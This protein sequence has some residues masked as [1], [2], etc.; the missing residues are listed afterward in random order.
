MRRTILLLSLGI[1]SIAAAPAQ[2]PQGGQPAQRRDTVPAWIQP[3]HAP[4]QDTIQG[5]PP[6]PP[7]GFNG[8]RPPEPPRGMP[9]GGF[10]G[11]RPGPG[12]PGRNHLQ[13]GS[14]S[15]TGYSQT[16]GSN[17]VEGKTY[18]S[19]RADENAV[20]IKGGTFTM[21]DCTI[22][23]KSGDTADGD[24]SSFFGTN[25]TVYA[26][27]ESTAV[28]MEGGRISSTATGVN[29]IIAYKGA[30][31]SARNVSIRTTG[32]FS[33]GL[34]ATG[35][36]IIQAQDLT[37]L[38]EG[39]NS[40]VIA[41]DRGGGTVTV[42]G[43]DYRTTGR[44]CA[45]LYSTG[46]ITLTDATGTSSQGE[47]G[48]I[49]GSNSLAIRNCQLTSGSTRRGLMVLQSG[50]GDAEGF[51]GGITVSGGELTLTS[52]TA[53]LIEVPTNITATITLKDVTLH[54]PS[55]TLMLVDYNRQWRTSGG[56]GTLVLTTDDTATYTGN[57][58]ADT[59]STAHVTVGKGVTWEG[60]L[61]QG[62]TAKH[63]S[64]T[65]S[66]KWVLTADSYATQV[67]V[68]AGGEI[69][70]NGHKLVC[71]SLEDRN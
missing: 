68:E 44:D 29:G 56:K 28:S 2:E 38:T 39:D 62:G 45:V 43:G 4:G 3:G 13:N 26:S 59:Y 69:D 27:G 32:R 63:A 55:G 37:I 61:N 11:G 50:S 42:K 31:V 9:P 35:G 18:T 65:V 52:D 5:R 70:R 6:M 49:E 19:T 7:G 16:E 58:D 8:E 67:T 25:S 54:V 10:G 15:Q 60:A 64:A 48:V 40:S 51:K 47:I 57:V 30:T 34:H 53:P 71:D 20:Q 24:G 46:N 66:G 41:T 36:G 23:K 17:A 21:K 12:G 22:E 33:R 1:G 14:A